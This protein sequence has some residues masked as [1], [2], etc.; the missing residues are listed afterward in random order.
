M[1]SS[2]RGSSHV[3][4]LGTISYAE[5]KIERIE[6]GSTNCLLCM[7]SYIVTL[8]NSFHAQCFFSK[9]LCAKSGTRPKHQRSDKFRYRIL[10]NIRLPYISHQLV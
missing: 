8:E 10:L 3:T 9:C 7:V 4:R 6:C 1:S 5:Y 2:P